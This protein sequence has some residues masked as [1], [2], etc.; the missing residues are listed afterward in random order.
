M[1][2]SETVKQWYKGSRKDILIHWVII[3]L[4]WRIWPVWKHVNIAHHQ[5]KIA[6]ARA[7]DILPSP[8]RS[9][10]PMTV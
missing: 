1:Q 9:Y 5:G 8:T 3:G 4:W 6:F 2:P 10:P 7:Q